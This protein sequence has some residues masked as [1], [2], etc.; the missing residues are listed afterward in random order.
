MSDSDRQYQLVTFY[1]GDE[2]YGIDIMVVKTIYRPEEI[3]PLP[4]APKYVQGILNLRGAI[5]PIINLHQRFHLRKRLLSESEEL[6]SG[7]IILEISN[8]QLGVI[9]DK[10]SRVVTVGQDAI[11]PPPEMLTGI[12]A[13]YIQGV[14]N[15]EE[16]YL[17]IL[18]TERIFNLRELQDISKIQ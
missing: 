17:L 1:L 9:I 5:V 7:I 16:G 3:R 11:Q 4:N 15:E 2:K 14:I 12:G 18:D 8:M 10:V 13:E 6:L